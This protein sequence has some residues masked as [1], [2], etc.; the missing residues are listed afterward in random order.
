MKI[1]LQ[2]II[3][4]IMVFSFCLNVGAQSKYN[5]NPTTKDT[6]K[7]TKIINLEYKYV[8]SIKELIA[9][10]TFIPADPNE[11]KKDRSISDHFHFW[12]EYFMSILIYYHI[13]YK[14]R[15]LLFP[16]TAKASLQ[17]DAD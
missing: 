9:N 5:P 16:D 10:G 14:L 1:L 2:K 12:K 3:V 13:I 8:P 17:I 4:M 15:F 6:H 7:V 11:F